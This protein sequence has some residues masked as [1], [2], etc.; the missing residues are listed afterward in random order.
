MS[1][2]IKAGKTGRYQKNISS[3]RLM[4]HLVEAKQEVEAIQRQAEQTLAQANLEK[5]NIFAEAKKKGHQ[6]GYEEGF[7]DGKE[8]GFEVANKKATENFLKEQKNILSDLQKI[9]T[10]VDADREN[11]Q[12]AAERNLLDFA[13]SLSSKLTFA[14]GKEYHESAIENVKRA[15]RLI[16]TKSNLTVRMHPDDIEAMEKFSQSMAKQIGESAAINLLPDESMAPGGCMVQNEHSDVDARLE[17][18]V[19]E[20]V[21]LLAGNKTNH[22]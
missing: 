6:A 17:T 14:I 1:T 10:E 16:G 19:D 13:I 3:L 8:N 22:G 5:E 12:I 18:Q 9:L 2:I 4:D 21:A 11:L 20:L 15:I 7:V